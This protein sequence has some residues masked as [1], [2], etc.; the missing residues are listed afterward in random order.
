MEIA[1]HQRHINEG[2]PRIPFLCP[3][4]HA[5]EE[6]IPEATM[7][8]VDADGMYVEVFG[9]VL[10]ETLGKSA[11]RFIRQFDEMPDPAKPAVVNTR[12]YRLYPPRQPFAA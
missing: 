8:N 11:K 1:I 12:P 3:I 9:Y 10:H 5:V 7:V 6:R 2:A 4:V